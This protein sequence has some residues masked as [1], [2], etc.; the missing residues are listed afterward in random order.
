MS[1]VSITHLFERAREFYTNAR[2]FL[3]HSGYAESISRL[4]CVFAKP[5]Y[6]SASR[7]IVKLNLDSV[8]DVDKGLFIRELT[9]ADIEEMKLVMYVS[10][11][12]L[13]QRFQKG[14]RCF[15]VLDGNN[16]L[17]FFWAEFNFKDLHELH[18]GLD[19]SS[20]QVW[21]Y[22]AVT[23]KSARGRNLYPNVIRYMAKVFYKEGIREAYIDVDPK[24]HASVRGLEKVGCKQ[25]A[26]VHMR[27]TLS[28]IRHKLWIIDKNLWHE[29]SKMIRGTLHIKSLKF[30]EENV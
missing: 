24:N 25:V 12:C 6:Q 30:R 2:I 15:A 10:S 26:R 14:D 5:F 28:L 13:R 1:F 9:D 27:K 4:C 18:I 29:L 17:S 16:I 23:I 20:H 22:N 7:Y 21:M 11:Y 19:L 3:R 8:S